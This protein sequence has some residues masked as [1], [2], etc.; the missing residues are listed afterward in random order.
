M[1]WK[2]DIDVK[3]VV[4]APQQVLWDRVSNHDGTGEWVKRW[5]KRVKVHT[6][7][8]EDRN[9]VGAI[10]GLKLTGWP[11]I[12][13]RVVLFEPPHKF[14]YSVI[15]GL[16][17]VTEQLGEVSVAWIDDDRSE[18]AWKVN[19][20]FNPWNPLSVSAPAMAKLLKWVFQGGLE[21]LAREYGGDASDKPDDGRGTGTPTGG[22]HR[23]TRTDRGRIPP[24]PRHA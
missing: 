1:G 7:G 21:Q 8:T 3:Q 14:K 5:V 4:D 24:L 22:V 16:P 11:E 9:G 12:M 23:P 17:M 6:P 13:E 2:F 10:R 18:V 15:S 19:M 20:E